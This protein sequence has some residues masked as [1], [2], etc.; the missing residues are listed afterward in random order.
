MTSAASDDDSPEQAKP[1]KKLFRR[2][3]VS[4][5]ALIISVVS[6]VVGGV[7][8]AWAPRILNIAAPGRPVVDVSVLG[9]PPASDPTTTATGVAGTS[10]AVQAKPD[11]DAEVQPPGAYNAFAFPQQLTAGEMRELNRIVAGETGGSGPGTGSLAWMRKNGAYDVGGLVTRVVVQAID[12]QVQ[13]VAVR[14]IIHKRTAPIG[15][16]VLYTPPEGSDDVVV[17]ALNLDKAQPSAPSF[18]NKT[19]S[20]AP[21]Q[22]AVIDVEA[23]ISKYSVVWQIGIDLMASGQP[24]TFVVNHPDGRPFRTTG[25][26]SAKAKLSN[27]GSEFLKQYA[28]P[29][30][31]RAGIEEGEIPVYI[32][33][34]P[35]Y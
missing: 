19:Q 2:I 20:L 13:L 7:M 32:K 1:A 14:A 11:A 9:S 29:W 17:A 10:P 26:P 3:T 12:Q 16:T 27:T 15:Q 6:L 31:F 4:T 34:F 25:L 28:D 8:V 22:A 21:G 24:Q 23:S 33:G 35:P 18:R 30:W 5:K